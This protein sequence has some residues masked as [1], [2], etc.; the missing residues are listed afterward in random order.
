MYIFHDSVY[1]VNVIMFNFNDSVNKVD[2]ILYDSVN[3]VEGSCKE[4]DIHCPNGRTEVI[5]QWVSGLYSED[6]E[7]GWTLCGQVYILFSKAALTWEH[8]VV[9]S[10]YV[11][12]PFCRILTTGLGNL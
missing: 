7:Y 5:G 4:C 2:V 3:N 10:C 8:H 12:V 6:V 9:I 11:F 1:K